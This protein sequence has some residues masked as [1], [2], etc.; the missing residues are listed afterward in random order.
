MR[1]RSPSAGQRLHGLTLA[2]ADHPPL[3]LDPANTRARRPAVPE[4]RRSHVS[5]PHVG[6]LDG[7]RAIAVIA[8]MLYHG[9]V[10]WAPGGF[11]GVEVFFVLSGFLISS[12]LLAEWA[13]SST[14]VLRA[15]WARRARRLL[16]ALFLLVLVIGVYYVIGGPAT[17]VP[18]LESNGL[19]TLLYVNNWHQIA[20]GANYF[21]ASGPVSPVQHT[22]SLAIEE[23]FYLLWPL[24]VLG[25]L[26]LAARRGAPAIRSLR[27]L[28]AL[29]LTGAVASAADTAVLYGSGH[30]LNRVY[31][32]TDT[33]AS[34]LLIGAALAIAL[35][36]RR[37][38]GRDDR[39][40]AGGPGIAEP[41]GAP[42]RCQSPGRAM[43]R[44]RW[45]LGVAAL[46]GLAAV[47][48]GIAVAAG[49]RGWVYPFGLLGLDAAVV[50]VI[51]GVVVAPAGPAA[52]LLS[53]RPLRGIGLISYG[54]YLW[55][56]PLFLWLDESSTGLRGT[57]LL[58]VRLA[59]TAAV[60]L[61]SYRFVEQPIRRRRAPAWVVRGLLPAAA[62]AAAVSLVLASAAASLPAGVPAAAQLPA[63]PPGLAGS[64]APCTETLSDTSQYGLAPLAPGKQ[65]KFEFT[66]LGYSTLAWRG[67]ATRT[68]HTCPP[69]R[70]LVVGD[71]L[72]FTIGVPMMG[73]EQ[74]YG[75][76]I[77]NAAQLGCAFA[78]RG[79]L[80]LN[81]SWAKLPASCPGALEQWARDERALHTQ[82][83]VVELGY[84][85][86]FNWLWNGR[87][88]HLG[89][90]AF[91][92]Y[93]QGQMDRYV[94]VLGRGG[95][96]ILFLSVP[97]THPPAQ[98]DG[99]PAAA[100]D[101]ARRTMINAMLNR[102]ARLHPHSVRVLDID[103]LISPGNHYDVRVD[104]RVCRFDGVHFSVFC[105]K[106]ME[107]TVMGEARHWLSR[108]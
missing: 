85:D 18:N 106:L 74:D 59:V 70:V 92:A 101:P 8:V 13:R 57:A 16:P 65:A 87:V 2:V 69:K 105:A 26:G 23:Q 76:E 81:G 27:L 54:L 68:F 86:E 96:K 88:V 41:P 43:A 39:R 34:G 12:L 84:R 79:E 98:A 20:N 72:A 108:R 50:I 97:Y 30:G 52:R 38:Q 15:F 32:G 62:G 7:L 95:T 21:A 6:A 66:A 46:A 89:Q 36:I 47:L 48:A 107:P 22:W 42:D 100:S 51:L 56:F 40:D 71:S 64:G 4:A 60:S 24:L 99:A 94:Q 37:R 49:G 61:L 45:L 73:D 25:A 44:R 104:G 1:R 31:Y 35:A 90:P 83:V 53:L 5:I 93:V 67:S 75:L 103:R 78:T 3:R 28:L 9:G 11:L 77:A 29:C 91:D 63:P 14:I 10:S 80:D 19:S 82:E 55:H 102:E 33:R 17:A 58:A